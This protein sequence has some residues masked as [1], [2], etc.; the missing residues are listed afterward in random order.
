[1]TITKSLPVD[2]TARCPN[3]GFSAVPARKGME[4]LEL[5]TCPSCEADIAI[6]ELEPLTLEDPTDGVENEEEPDDL[7]DPDEDDLG[8]DEEDW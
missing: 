3:C 4:L 8:E 1:M 6:V 7:L 5:V 2:S